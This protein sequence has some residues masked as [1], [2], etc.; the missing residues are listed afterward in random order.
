MPNLPSP[1]NVEV[2]PKGPNFLLIV[3][4]S[5]VALFIMLILAY[6]IVL[7]AGDVLVPSAHQNSE[8]TGHLV[9]A[10]LS[11]FAV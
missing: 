9:R 2:H 1:A 8:A 7:G 4:L 5:G 11:R 6:L 3:I 10:A